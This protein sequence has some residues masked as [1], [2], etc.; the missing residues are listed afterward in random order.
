MKV[1]DLKAL[2]KERGLRGYS[3]MRKAEL[4][5]FIQD[6][7]QPCARPPPQMFTWSIDDRQMSTN[8]YR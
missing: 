3:K 1:V 2:A 4:I 6:N 7:L 8:V 5:T